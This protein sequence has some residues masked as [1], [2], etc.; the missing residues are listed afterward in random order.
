[1]NSFN[2][3]IILALIPLILSIGIIPSLSFADH[4]MIMSPRK[5]MANGV[6]A[7]DVICKEGLALCM[8]VHVCMCV[9][10]CVWCGHTC[11]L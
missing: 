7:E 4:H 5:Q 11:D 9:C 1:M 3:I 2:T 10:E 8:C 6:A